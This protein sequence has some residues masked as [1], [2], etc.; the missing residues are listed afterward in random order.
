MRVWFVDGNQFNLRAS[1]VDG[2]FHAWW[3]IRGVQS[4]G[5]G[6]VK[7]KPLH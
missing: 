5:Y 7:K 3:D 4:P 1:N 6:G 2:D